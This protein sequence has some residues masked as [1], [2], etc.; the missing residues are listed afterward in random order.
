MLALSHVGSTPRLQ[1][2]AGF[3][4]YAGGVRRDRAGLVRAPHTPHPAS[5]RPSA[6]GA[7]GGGAGCGRRRL[8]TGLLARG[9]VPVFQPEWPGSSH[10]WKQEDHPEPR[11]RC[12]SLESRQTWPSLTRWGLRAQLCRW[13]GLESVA[14]A[15]D[16]GSRSPP[17]VLPGRPGHGT[18]KPDKKVTRRSEHRPLPPVLS[19]EAAACVTRGS[20][21][22]AWTSLWRRSRVHLKDLAHVCISVCV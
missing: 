14:P 15:G 17:P 6:V 1:P 10:R 13:V 19:P 4:L 5:H 11:K 16:W 22:C 20:R 3:P 2:G 18:V 7:P 9:K 21:L 8:G 12:L